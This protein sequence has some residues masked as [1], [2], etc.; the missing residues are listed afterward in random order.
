MIRI[1]RSFEPQDRDVAAQLFWEAF[2][3]KLGSCLGPD[4][5][6]IRF[7]SIVMERNFCFAAY[8]ENTLLGLAG[9]KTQRGGLIGGTLSDLTGIYG[10]FGGVWRAVLLSFFERNMRED[11]LLMDGICVASSA[12]GQGVGT[13]LLDALTYFAQSEEKSEIRLDV[14][15]TNPRARH[16]YE[17]HGFEPSGQIGTGPLRILFGFR[18]ATTMVRPVTPSGSPV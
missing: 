5:R 4:E 8:E 3:G 10:L 16:L 17:R 11:Q 7:I 1:Q 9:F 15:D 14:I 2:G 6:A 12:R 13:L 18:S